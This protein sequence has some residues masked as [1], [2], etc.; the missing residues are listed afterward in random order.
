MQNTTNHSHGQ[1]H[2]LNIYISARRERRRTLPRA[3]CALS[4]RAILPQ[5]IYARFKG[6]FFSKPTAVLTKYQ[7]QPVGRP[8]GHQ[9]RAVFTHCKSQWRLLPARSNPQS[10]GV[11]RSPANLL[12]TLVRP[13]LPL[14][15]LSDRSACLIEV[16]SI[17]CG[18]QSG[19]S[20]WVGLASVQFERKR[21]SR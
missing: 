6:M 20:W 16:S 15:D 18:V 11:L 1:T 19:A 8:G 12:A 5:Y 7:W 10:H 9:T 14:Y 21:D 13:R 4:F 2:A 3:K 17:G